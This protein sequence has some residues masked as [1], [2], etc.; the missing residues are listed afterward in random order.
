MR[1]QLI[2]SPFRLYKTL[3]TRLLGE[4]SYR[5]GGEPLSKKFA[6]FDFC[7]KG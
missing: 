3:Q 7:E 4:D 6:A 2:Y 1:E 5:K